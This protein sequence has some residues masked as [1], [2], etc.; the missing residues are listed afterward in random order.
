MILLCGASVT[1]QTPG[2]EDALN[3]T[4]QGQYRRAVEQFSAVLT[5]P[6]VRDDVEVHAFVLSQMAGAYIQMGEY[7]Q[8]EARTQG[9]IKI[10]RSAQMTESGTFAVVEGVVA[11]LLRTKG[12]YDEAGRIAEQALALGKRTLPPASARLG[13]LYTTLAGISQD[14][15]DFKRSLDLC[16]HAAQ[17]FAEAG[18]ASKIELGSA[19]QNLAVAYAHRGKPH[20]ALDMTSLALSTWKEV[21][22]PNHPFVVYALCTQVVAYNHLKAF[23]E[24]EAIIP[25]MLRLMDADPNI[26]QPERIVIL[27]NTA[28]VYAAEKKYENA[29]TMLRTA[30]ATGRQ[31]LPSGHPLVRGTFLNYSHVLEKLNREQDAA[32]YRAEADVLLAFPKK[33]DL[34][35]R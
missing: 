5:S 35:P 34:G 13:I 14:R 3:L 15:G 16:Q 18:P 17:I 10:L 21:L 26:S 24:A 32:R 30:V 4:R 29:E 22:P 23:Q 11:D 27:N 8:A 6:V 25:E 12:D 7:A 31:H 33:P 1:A 20:K 28:A 19:Y 9:A 2:V